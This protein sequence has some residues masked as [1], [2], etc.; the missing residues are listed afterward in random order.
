M[1]SVWILQ[2]FLL[3]ILPAQLGI[4]QDTLEKL[5]Y[6]RALATFM[7]TKR[8]A[9]ESRFDA[10]SFQRLNWVGRTAAI[11][12][13]CGSNKEKACRQA[14]F[15]GLTDNAL[16]VRDHALR[17]ML[18]HSGFE[19]QEKSLASER[20]IKDDRNYRRG[21]SLWIVERARQFLK[22]GNGLLVSRGVRGR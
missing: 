16:V 6:K 21:A 11:N 7:R 15:L 20:V 17:I 1:R 4:A 12:F 9:Q 2:F 14:L 13:A 3:L 8:T 22:T 10:K 18:A 5:E 19:Q